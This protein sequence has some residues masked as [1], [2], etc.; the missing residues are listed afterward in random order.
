MVQEAREMIQSLGSHAQHWAGHA[1]P[2][3]AASPPLQP[4]WKVGQLAM[5]LREVKS[6]DIYVQ[7]LDFNV[8]N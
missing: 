2:L 6:L 5:F 8:S 1:F 4:C 3:G 7:V